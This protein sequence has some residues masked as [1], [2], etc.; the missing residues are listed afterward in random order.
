MLNYNYQKKIII[1]I[2]KLIKHLIKH[3]GKLDRFKPN[4][5]LNVFFLQNRT[6]LTTTQF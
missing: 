5:I 4:P 2:K 3:R 1:T 6:K